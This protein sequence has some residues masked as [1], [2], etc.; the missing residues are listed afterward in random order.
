MQLV[1]LV[2]SL[3]QLQE[4]EVVVLVLAHVMRV[5]PRRNNALRRLG[6]WLRLLRA[7]QRHQE[8]ALELVLPRPRVRRRLRQA[9]TMRPCPSLT[10]HPHQLLDQHVRR[11]NTRRR[12]GICAAQARTATPVEVALNTA[13][14]VAVKQVELDTEAIQMTKM[15]MLSGTAVLI[16]DLHHH[17]RIR[18]SSLGHSEDS[19]VNLA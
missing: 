15:M 8:R 13:A 4:E 7:K 2:P 11:R 17:Q 10:M 19:C 18:P 16:Q 9:M 14:Q 1:R 5:Q 12:S 6:I 3:L